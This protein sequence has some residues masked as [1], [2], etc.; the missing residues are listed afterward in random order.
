MSPRLPACTARQVLAALQKTGWYVHHSTGSHH[1]LRHPDKPGLRVT[2][3][4]HSRDIPRP[5]LQLIL[6][7]AGLSTEEFI[8]LL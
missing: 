7:Q 6:K 1:I 2:V 5:T 3:A 8:Q 4:V